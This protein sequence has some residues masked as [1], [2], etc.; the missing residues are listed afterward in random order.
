MIFILIIY[1]LYYEKKKNK[2]IHSEF[3]LRRI[4]RSINN[5]PTQLYI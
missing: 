4:N 2:K 1:L 5:L 3:R